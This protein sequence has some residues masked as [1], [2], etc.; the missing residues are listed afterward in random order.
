MIVTTVAS[1]PSCSANRKAAI[2]FLLEIPE[3]LEVVRHWDDLVRKNPHE[4]LWYATLTRDGMTLT[5]T[6]AAHLGR[7]DLVERD[8]RI[9]CALAGVPYLSPHKLRHGHIVHA[10]KQ[11]RTMAELKAISQNVMHASVTITDQVYGRL[12]NNDVRQ[13]ISGL[14]HS[15]SAL[16]PEM[17]IG[18]MEY[19]KQWA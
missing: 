7:G 17:I 11:A 8:L 5:S 3:L 15:P 14:G 12:V 1:G 13:I 10:L 19:L 2:T 16:P 6:T 18:L 4:S 9:A